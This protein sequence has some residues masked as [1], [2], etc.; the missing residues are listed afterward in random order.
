MSRIL[1]KNNFLIS[2]NRASN[3][4]FEPILHD[5]LGSGH[6]GCAGIYK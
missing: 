4:K 1:P 2:V 5:N 3:S 6:R